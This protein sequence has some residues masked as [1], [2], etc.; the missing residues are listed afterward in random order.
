MM[1][2][3]CASMRVLLF[4][5][6]ACAVATAF[7]SPRSRGRPLAGR[8]GCVRV[9]GKVIAPGVT[10]ADRRNALVAV[11]ALGALVAF[12]GNASAACEAE[13]P[14]PTL[15]GEIARDGVARFRPYYQKG[16]AFVDLGSGEGSSLLYFAELFPDAASVTGIEYVQARHDAAVRRVRAK[17]AD[18]PAPTSA[19]EYHYGQFHLYAGDIFEPRFAKYFR[20][21]PLVYVSNLCF[22]DDMNRR[23]AR[24][25]RANAGAVVFSSVELSKVG[26]T[27]TKLEQTWG[28]EGLGYIWRVGDLQ[29]SACPIYRCDR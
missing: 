14:Y 9:D 16:R 13:K 19:A 6:A 27:Q 22:R 23:V 10:D 26:S 17:F 28:D 7:Q 20:E 2:V 21:T 18:A 4:L 25:L 5:A 12:G 8:L 29:P 11:A 3:N 24:A 15:Y 1:M